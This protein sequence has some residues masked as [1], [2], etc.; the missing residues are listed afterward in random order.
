M[1]QTNREQRVPL[2]FRAGTT[3]IVLQGRY[4]VTNKLGA[5]G[6]S[7]VYKARDMRFGGV[8][9]WCAIK[10]MLN[11]ANDPATRRA[12]LE[13]FEREANILASLSH[14]AIPKVYDFFSQDNRS[15]LVLEF[16]E[17]HDLEELWMRVK[18]PLPPKDVVNWAL[19]VCDVLTYLHDQQPPVV[20]RDIKPSNVMLTTKHQRI[21]LIDFGIAKVFQSGAKGTMIGTEGY[22][23]PEQYRGVAE[24]RGDLYALGATMHH[25]LSGMDPRLE[26]PFT[27]HERALRARNAD[28]SQPLEDAIKKALLYEADQRYASAREMS[29]A[30]VRAMGGSGTLAGSAAPTA[31]VTPTRPV[32]AAATAP[33][34]IQTIRPIWQFKCEDEVRSSPRILDNL[35]YFGCYDHNLYALDIRNG[36]F[37]W[38]YPT[39]GGI[40]STPFVT[41][42]MLYIGSEDHSLYALDP[43]SGNLRWQART[44]GP[45]RS[46]PRAAS[47]LV[48][49]GSDDGGVHA[50]WS[51]SGTPVWRF[52]TLQSVRSSPLIANETVIIGADE[53]L[54]YGIQVRDGRQRWKYNAGRF[55]ISTP[56]YDDGLA[57]VGSGD[58]AVHAIDARSG[59]PIWRVRTGGPI[60]SSPCIVEGIVYIGSSD[61]NLY[62]LDVRSG[63]TIWKSDAGCQIVSSPAVVNRVVSFGSQDGRLH[64]LDARTGK[65]LWTYQTGGMITSSPLVHQGRVYIGSTDHCLYALPAT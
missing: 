5:G 10:E 15:Y 56:A 48:I 20:F 18:G 11:N 44:K 57:I 8:E 51:A 30:L 7:T 49:V 42:D 32:E 47:D 37:V 14:P 9:R 62:A 4:E 58:A 35:I 3:K 63:R 33:V 65:S 29:Q 19:Q 23:P 52:A 54:V 50:F 6:M 12:N 28:V 16:I 25:L 59:W 39:E 55:V 43:K 38:K 61:G 2:N 46:S 34:S 17:G 60:V 45:V 36:K 40:S 22:A 21:V 53:G 27:F 1:G 41:A 64:A 31:G 26:A 13:A 24:P